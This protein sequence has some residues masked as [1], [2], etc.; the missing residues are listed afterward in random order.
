[1]Q[2]I[3]AEIFIFSGNFCKIKQSLKRRIS[4]VYY[5]NINK[6]KYCFTIYLYIDS[7]AIR[8][9]HVCLAGRHKLS[10]IVSRFARHGKYALAYRCNVGGYGYVIRF[11]RNAFMK[12]YCHIY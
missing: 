10:L 12:I 8:V 2:K 3:A 1:M 7:D 9:Q 5:I 6:I 11:F 4:R